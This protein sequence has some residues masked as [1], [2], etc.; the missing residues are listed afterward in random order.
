[1]STEIN[2]PG[3]MGWGLDN[4]TPDQKKLLERQEAEVLASI[5]PAFC[6]QQEA[7]VPVNEGLLKKIVDLLTLDGFEDGYDLTYIAEAVYGEP[8]EWLAQIIGSCVASGGMRGWTYRS[9]H[10]VFLFGEFEELFGTKLPGRESFAHFGPYSYRAGRRLANMNSGDGSYCS[11]H[12]RGLMQFGALPCSI[13]G[14]ESDA[15]PEPQSAA[16]Y[17]RWGG[18]AGNALM[19]QFAA[20]KQFVLTESEEVTAVDQ[21]QKLVVDHKK[22]LMICSMWAFRPDYQHPTAKLR[23]GT[24]IWIYKRDTSTS[25]AHNMTIVAFLKIGGKWFVKVLNSWPKSSHKNGFWF[26][27]PIEV[28][29]Q[30]LASNNTES[31]SIG[32]IDLADSVAPIFW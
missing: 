11:V 19:D 27:I 22:P 4:E 24:P 8:L 15:F 30:W 32:N 5:A 21:A 26:L 10:E 2:N 9:L 16:L 14:L 3:L 1:M 25:W 7:K 17:R 29:G 20:A 23:D 28:F 12:I 13:T 18:S 6:T 31:R